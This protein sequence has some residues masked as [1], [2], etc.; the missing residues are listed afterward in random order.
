MVSRTGAKAVDGGCYGETTTRETTA[1]VT[2]LAIDYV[3]ALET[4]KLVTSYS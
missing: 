1:M 4:S 2:K 3:N